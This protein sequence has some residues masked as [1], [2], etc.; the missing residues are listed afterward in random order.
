MKKDTSILIRLETDSQIE[1]KDL[2]KQKGYNMSQR[3]R[4]FIEQ[5]VQE[6]KKELKIK[7]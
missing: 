1:Y 3:I 2:C 6:L 7:K 5:E 4:N